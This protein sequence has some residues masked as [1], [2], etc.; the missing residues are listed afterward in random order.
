MEKHHYF[1]VFSMQVAITVSMLFIGN[2]LYS[3][4]AAKPKLILQI[5]VDQFKGNLPTKYMR[6]MGQGGYRSLLKDGI[7][8]NKVHYGQANTETVV[9]HTTLAT[10]EDLT[11]TGIIANV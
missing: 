11:T 4:N 5:T 2:V 1:S 8:Y 7:W 9:G 10:D 3:Q 6:N